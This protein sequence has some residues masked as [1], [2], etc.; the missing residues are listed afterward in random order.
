MAP[1]AC[2]VPRLPLQPVLENACEHTSFEGRPPLSVRIRIHTDTALGPSPRDAGPALVIDVEDD[3][4]GIPPEK[5]AAL[6]EKLRSGDTAPQP[7]PHS[8]IGLVNVN[9]RIQLNYGPA[10]GLCVDSRE[11]EGTPIELW[12]GPRRGRA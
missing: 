4:D 6:L 5:L 10:Y 9:R 11:G 1:S 12:L 8:G 7:G 3:G 2:L